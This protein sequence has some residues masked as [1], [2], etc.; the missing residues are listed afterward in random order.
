MSGLNPINLILILNSLS[1]T[2]LVIT[3]NETTRDEISKK[4]STTNPLE[5]LLWVLVIFEL[6]ILLIQ[7]K[8]SDL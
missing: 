3:Q 1:V 5:R 4:S 7:T 6:V 8:V 2:G